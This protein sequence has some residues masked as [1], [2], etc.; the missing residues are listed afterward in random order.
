MARKKTEVH[1]M[2]QEE[3]LE[4]R[5]LVKSL[6]DMQDMRIR[7]SGRLQKKADG[8]DMKDNGTEAQFIN[9]AIFVNV[10]LNDSLKETEAEYAKKL[11]SI[12][13]RTAE[14]NLFLKDVKGCGPMMAAVLITEID[15]RKASTVS[16]IWQYA[17][18]N[19]DKVR[20]KKVLKDGTI[21]VTNDLIRG[22][23]L[24]AG[25][26]AP[27]NI[28]LK[29]KLLGVLATCFIKS[30]S[31][32]TQFYYNDKTR[33]SNSNKEYKEGKPWKDESKAHIDSA[34]RR[35]MV[36]A[37]LKDYYANVR[38]MYGLEVRESYE[39]EYLGRIHHTA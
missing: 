1:F 17:G 13:E 23:R 32:Y 8:T 29:T 35:Y 16:K 26:L 27:F 3:R 38:T 18:M 2:T 14:W 9:D 24:T 30:K 4:L 11:K 39:Q 5:K 6:Y 34:A 21:I 20:G 25:Y 7:T 22:D 37:F 31:E 12:I 36:K 10:D 28:H 19:P 15:I 33:K